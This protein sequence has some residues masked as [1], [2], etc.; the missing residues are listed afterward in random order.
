VSQTRER[1]RIDAAIAARGAAAQPYLSD[2]A[3]RL[4]FELLGNLRDLLQ[5]AT[6]IA[7][8]RL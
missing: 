3:R 8:Q 2:R 7:A 1:H 6:A 4:L 5:Y